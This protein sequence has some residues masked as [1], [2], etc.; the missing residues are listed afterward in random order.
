MERTHPSSTGAGRFRSFGDGS[1]S[2]QSST[3]SAIISDS[4][5]SSGSGSFAASY[6]QEAFDDESH[7]DEFPPSARIVGVAVARVSD[8][9]SGDYGSDEFEEDQEEDG[10]RLADCGPVETP[11]A[12]NEG[13]GERGN[14]GSDDYGN[15]SFESEEQETSNPDE[16]GRKEAAVLEGSESEPEHIVAE[17]QL[18]EDSTSCQDQ[19]ARCSVQCDG[20]LSYSSLDI[21]STNLGS[22]CSEKLAVLNG[23]MA[24][25]R[26]GNQGSSSPPPK[27][28]LIT[29]KIPAASVAALIDRTIAQRQRQPPALPQTG[30]G[31]W[32]RRRQK[33]CVSVPLMQRAQTQRWLSAPVIDTKTTAYLGHPTPE[34]QLIPSQSAPTTFCSVKQAELRG[35][36]ATAQLPEAM[37]RWGQPA[38]GTSLVTLEFLNDMAIAQRDVRTS[39]E[40]AVAS[41]TLHQTMLETGLQLEASIALRRQAEG[42]LGHALQERR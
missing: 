28:K 33:V 9:S 1:S 8:G 4:A 34:A 22:W 32:P 7:R 35:R 30:G 15:A 17:P 23:T 21:G 10:D 36:L 31:S 38:T 14:D 19:T 18:W 40:S 24:T 13:E 11:A 20:K 26:R 41:A 16:E 25:E 5:I 27:R 37:N 39:V 42:I 2:R 6:G 12:A 3:T 29:D